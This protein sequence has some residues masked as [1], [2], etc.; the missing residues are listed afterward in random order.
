MSMSRWRPLTSGVTQGSVLGSV[1]VN[2]FI[3]YIDEGI[4]FILNNFADDIK[5]MF[6]TTE[7]ILFKGTWTD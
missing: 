7:V 3:N 2:N 4:K 6:H 1:L 5:M